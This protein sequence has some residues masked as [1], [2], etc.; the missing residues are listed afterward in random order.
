MTFGVPGQTKD[1][2]RGAG[3]RPPMATE[4]DAKP[5]GSCVPDIHDP[6]R[7]GRS[8]PLAVAAVGAE[9][10][11][12]DFIGVLGEGQRLLTPLFV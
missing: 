9:R 2:D 3:E 12:A 4:L 6:I 1:S 5:A 10:H 8:D 11:V 7:A